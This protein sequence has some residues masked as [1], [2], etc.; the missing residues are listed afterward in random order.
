MSGIRVHSES[1]INR[2]FDLASLPLRRWFDRRVPAPRPRKGSR[3]AI[4]GYLSQECELDR[5]PPKHKLRRS[6][7]DSPVRLSRIG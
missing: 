6:R 1:K 7:P 5:T 4:P 3:I 2:R